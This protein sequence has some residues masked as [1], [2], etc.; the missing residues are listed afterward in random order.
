MSKL[1]MKEYV[2]AHLKRDDCHVGSTDYS[3]YKR[4]SGHAYNRFSTILYRVQQIG[5]DYELEVQRFLFARS[6]YK[7]CSKV[8][9]SEPAS[10]V[11]E[12]LHRE[13][14]IVRL[15]ARLARQV[16]RAISLSLVAG[17]GEID[18]VVR[19]VDDA[20]LDTSSIPLASDVRGVIHPQ[21]LS[22]AACR[23]GKRSG[24]RHVGKKDVTHP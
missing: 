3:G 20:E 15:A 16:L 19:E 7:V 8:L 1:E 21:D 6:I 4:A 22:V 5:L 14:A 10:Y 13:R 23:R 9:D 18:H 11:F 2:Y 12:L 24:Q 17:Y